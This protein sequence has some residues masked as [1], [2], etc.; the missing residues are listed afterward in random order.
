MGMIKKIRRQDSGWK[1]AAGCS[2]ETSINLSNEIF[3]FL[4]YGLV[5]S[6]E[7]CG[8]TFRIYKQDYIDAL[9]FIKSQLPLY[10]STSKES[11]KIE[12]DNLIF[13]KLEDS[14]VN[15]FGEERS[16][17]YTVTMYR[18]KDGRIY[19]KNLKQ[20]GFT[21]RDYL[22]EFSSALDFE[23]GEDCFELRLIPFYV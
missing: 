17:V 23:M 19:L 10:R 11:I 16:K 5:D 12:A 4:S 18:R 13:E 22:V 2:G 9:D 21:I 20:K 8:I 6:G 7:E 15:F 1:Q 14:I 3:E